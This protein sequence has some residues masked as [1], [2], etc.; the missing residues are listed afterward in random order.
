MAFLGSVS[1]L[2]F[3]K[4]ESVHCFPSSDRPEYPDF[5]DCSLRV[6]DCSAELL[7]ESV[8]SLRDIAER[9]A[10]IQHYFYSV[11]QI[12]AVPANSCYHMLFLLFQSPLS[13]YKE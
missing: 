5:V 8:Y 10:E 4:T 13:N 2:D 11:Q 6:Q 12:F 1:S 9:I 3:E 7:E